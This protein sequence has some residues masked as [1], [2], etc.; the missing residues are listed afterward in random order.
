MIKIKN[1]GLIIAIFVFLALIITNYIPGT[2]LTGWDNLHP[3]FNFILSIKRS[4]FSV[5]QEYQGL[6]LLAGTGYVAE[7]PR[8]ILLWLMSSVLP[9]SFLR[10]FYHFF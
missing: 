2:F 6:G 3:E 5:W 8:Q 4:I 9:F 1:V 10:Y 7:L